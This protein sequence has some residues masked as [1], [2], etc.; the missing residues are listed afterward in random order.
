MG[1]SRRGVG[2]RLGRVFPDSAVQPRT[3]KRCAYQDSKV[4]A[5]EPRLILTVHLEPFNELEPLRDRVSVVLLALPE[6]VRLDLL[7]DPRFRMTLD[8][9]TPGA[10]RTVWLACPG[11]RGNGSRSVVLK[12]R[13]ADCAEPFAHYIIAHELAHAH[14]RNGGWGEID[15]PETAA[16]ALAASWGFQKPVT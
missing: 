10:G 8:Q 7:T 9:L 1:H 12:P 15:D 16:D 3:Q 11:S 6:D 13:L 4:Q 2:W 5:P 14:L